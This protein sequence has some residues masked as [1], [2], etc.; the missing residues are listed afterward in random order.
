MKN[1]K[2]N[3]QEL[4]F[5]MDIDAARSKNIFSEVTGDAKIKTDVFLSVSELEFFF[6][7]IKSI[8]IRFDGC[9]AVEFNLNQKKSNYLKYLHSKPMIKKLSF[10][11][12][13]TIFNKILNDDQKTHALDSFKRSHAYLFGIESM[14]EQLLVIKNK[15]Q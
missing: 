1:L 2:L 12:G 15:I 4:A 10:T 13:K 14:E 3:Y 8:D 6:K 9:N 7:K 5:I 11:S